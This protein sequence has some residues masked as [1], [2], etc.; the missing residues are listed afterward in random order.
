MPRTRA[1]T[2]NDKS[3]TKNI[4]PRLDTKRPCTRI[5][6]NT[7]KYDFFQ[8]GLFPEELIYSEMYYL[9]QSMV[10]I[11]SITIAHNS[12]RHE[13]KLIFKNSQGNKVNFDNYLMLLCESNL[14]EY[15]QALELYYCSFTLMYKARIELCKGWRSEAVS[16][17]LMLPLNS[18]KYNNLTK[19]CGNEM[20]QRQENAQCYVHLLL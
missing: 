6:D 8:L 3:K 10:C 20:E 2:S 5:P 11:L 13:S 12:T 16:P 9:T 17:C 14:E 15:S 1:N 7:G 4:N 18:I 19:L